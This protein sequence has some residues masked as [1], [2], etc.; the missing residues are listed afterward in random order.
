[1]ARE[2]SSN[3][4]EANWLASSHLLWLETLPTGWLALWRTAVNVG[5]ENQGRTEG[6][7]LVQTDGSRRGNFDS[8]WL[9]DR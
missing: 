4:L 9:P 2:A 3:R 7:Q 1:M 6:G 5:E 8:Y